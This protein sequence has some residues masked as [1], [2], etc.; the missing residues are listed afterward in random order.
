MNTASTTQ[1]KREEKPRI[2]IYEVE[3]VL[4]VCGPDYIYRVADALSNETR[5]QI[6]RHVY[7]KEVDVGDI[8]KLIKQSK[9]NASAQIKKLE[10][11]GLIKT[12]YKPGQRGVKKVCTSD[13]REIRIYLEC[14][15]QA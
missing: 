13:I 14:E 8:S 9:A 7:K 10:N 4:H 15:E 5:I 12:I 11:A 1:E 3:G 2:G 6:L